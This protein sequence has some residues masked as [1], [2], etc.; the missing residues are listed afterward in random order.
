MSDLLEIFA[1]CWNFV[2]IFVSSLEM[3]AISL[4]PNQAVKC[5]IGGKFCKCRN[6][7][8]F[9]SV[10]FGEK[11]LQVSDFLLFFK[12]RIW[13]KVLQVSE[14]FLDFFCLSAS[15]FLSVRFC[16]NFC[17]CRN[18]FLIFLSKC[19]IFSK[20]RTF[21]NFLQVSDFLEIFTSV[22]FLG[23]FYKCRISWK[24]LQVSELFL[25]FLVNVPDFFLSKCRFF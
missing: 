24:I 25:A 15:I 3:P 21:L 8:F 4:V 14:L 5:S 16:G 18:F 13:W 10:G 2:L 20:C 12:C 7:F 22:E 19:Q 9:L 17:K 23:N 1:K 11:F 6:F